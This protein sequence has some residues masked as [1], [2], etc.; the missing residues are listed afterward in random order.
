[1]KLPV[2]GLDGITMNFGGEVTPW[3]PNANG[4]PQDGEFELSTKVVL[5]A[6]EFTEI[7]KDGE[8][9]ANRIFPFKVTESGI[10]V[11]VEN[12]DTHY[13]IE[14]EIPTKE[15]K[16]PVPV[17]DLFSHGFGNVFGNISGQVTIWLAT[18]GPMYI[19][20]EL[21]ELTVIYILANSEIEKDENNAEIPEKTED[22]AVE[23]I[24]EDLVNQAEQAELDAMKDATDNENENPDEIVEEKPKLNRRNK[25][26]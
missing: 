3:P 13:K 17:Q 9:I 19:K 18:D 23:E 4:N 2:C 5:D 1:V 21:S 7:V 24:D 16:T 11:T 14:R 6:D 12:V 22:P 26:K 15:V 25:K 20:K 8:Q 10:V